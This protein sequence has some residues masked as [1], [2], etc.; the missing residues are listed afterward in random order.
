MN[1]DLG[2]FAPALAVLCVFAAYPGRV[3]GR[4][5]L[6]AA[7]ALSLWHGWE[8][9]VASA[10]LAM[11]AAALLLVVLS[12]VRVL[13]R[14]SAFAILACAVG[15]PLPGWLLF[16]PGLVAA[17][18]VSMLR[19]RREEGRGY[20]SYVAGE[21]FSAMGMR[22]GPGGP[23]GKPEV[24]RVPMPAAHTGPRVPFLRLTAFS[25]LAFWLV[26]VVALNLY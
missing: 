22:S 14:D 21:M 23:L 18:A 11:L 3:P 10:A 20:V 8:F 17:G 24:S 26:L 12:V 16:L 2:M 15:L 19:L 7:G 13:S 9:G 6:V 1:V 25:T 5:Y 4:V